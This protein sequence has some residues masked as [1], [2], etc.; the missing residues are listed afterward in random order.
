MTQVTVDGVRLHVLE[1]GRG[2]AVLLLHGV[3]VH[4]GLWREVI[5]RLAPQLRA[6]APD[7][8]G[9]GASDKPLELDYGL[10]T[11]VRL[12]DGLIGA[13]GLGDVVLVGMDL[14]LMVAASYA[15]AHPA[16]V[17]G[18]VLLEGILQPLDEAF[19][20]MPLGAR[21]LMRLLRLRPVAERALVRDGERSL[22][23]M[24]RQGTVRPLAAEE[25]ESY[26]APW[27]DAAVRRRV[28]LEG[29][30]PH[31]LRPRSSRPGDLP[32]LVARYAAFL[33]ASPLPKLLLHA[34][35]GAAIRARALAYA[36]ARIPNLELRAVGAGKHFLPL[37]Q[38]AAIAEAIVDFCR[39][40]SGTG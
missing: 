6:V 22:A 20:G 5:P 38:P 34:E 37:D 16:A 35:P 23:R 24:I 25:L 4:S 14:G 36:R 3:P 11:H 15:A 10:A 31:T 27:R 32:D 40:L 26:Q 9:F 19:A 2:P 28:W 30:G 18:L 21:L 33:A 13:L 8:A 7:L 12:L 39:R 17:R 1:E 29:V